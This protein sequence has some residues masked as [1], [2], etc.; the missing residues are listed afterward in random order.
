MDELSLG[1]PLPLLDFKG[2]DKNGKK[3]KKSAPAADKQQAPKAVPTRPGSSS[4]AKPTPSK[5][6]VP[7]VRGQVLLAYWTKDGEIGG[8]E[9]PK[10]ASGR[11]FNSYAASLEGVASIAGNRPKDD[12]VPQTDA[13]VLLY[14]HQ[15]VESILEATFLEEDSNLSSVGTQPS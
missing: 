6:P 11:Y 1:H 4:N 15:L 14:V 2:K 8:Q 12:K 5:A 7:K 3:S 10:N 13:K 9:P